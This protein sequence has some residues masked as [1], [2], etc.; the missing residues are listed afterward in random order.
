MVR[1]GRFVIKKVGD[2]Y[3]FEL[4]AS[5]YSAIAESPVYTTLDSAKR[6]IRSIMENAHSVP[7]Q[8]NTV[9]EQIKYPNPKFEVFRNGEYYFFRF[10][11]GNGK[12]TISSQVYTSKEGCKNG[13]VSVQNH[14]QDAAICIETAE[15]IVSLEEYADMDDK[16][17]ADAQDPTILNPDDEEVPEEEKSTR[18][19]R[20]MIYPDGK[21]FRFELL[22]ANF[23]SIADSPT[24]STLDSVKRSIRSLKEYACNVPVQDNTVEPVEKQ[25]N[26]KF[27]IFH[28]DDSYIFRFRAKNG[29]QT[30]SSQQYTTKDGCR[31]GV[32][33]VQK[34]IGR[35]EVYIETE[36]G[37]MPIEEY[38]AIR[39]AIFNASVFRKNAAAEGAET[40]A[41]T[42]TLIPMDEKPV[43]ETAP[44]EETPVMEAPVEETAATETPAE[45]TPVEETP[46][47]EAPAEEAPVEETPAEETPAE[48]APVEET[49]A[50]ETPAEETPVE[51]TPVEEAPAEEAPVEETPAEETPAE[52]TPAE[53]APVEEAPVEEAP[54]EETPA[55]ETPAEETPAEETP[56]E[57]APV[58]EA[59]VE[60]TPAE[61]TPAEEA[62][63]AKK[64]V[65]GTA[66][67]KRGFGHFLAR[68][69]FG[70]KK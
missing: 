66:A 49:A 50:T 63:A 62:P 69:L 5:N 43:E 34:H 55:E 61:E 28:S 17:L 57:E 9:E 68:M 15:G 22:A 56:V 24:Y 13:V 46:V 59:P 52:E 64:P 2:G 33:S 48:E 4:Q 45:E 35:A 25:P 6:S 51:E 14:V 26:P 10:R 54:V 37:P 16:T 36:D 39:I 23:S 3:M 8:D 18:P 7:V 12:M 11:A 19:G 41:P 31:N 27:E 38:T 47:E 29:K 30:I 60:E 44:V 58:E 53:E 40:A 42:E 65:T 67:K 32:E 70:S 21:T 20:F 1:T